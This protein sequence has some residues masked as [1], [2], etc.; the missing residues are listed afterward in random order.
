MPHGR[1]VTRCDTFYR[2]S[3]GSRGASKSLYKRKLKGKKKKKIKENPQQLESI[4]HKKKKKNSSKY[5]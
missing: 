5:L 3:S 1:N 2:K 4:E